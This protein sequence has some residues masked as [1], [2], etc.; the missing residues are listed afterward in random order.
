MADLT[1]E[2]LLRVADLF[3]R[4]K[5]PVAPAVQEVYPN[6][7]EANLYSR[8]CEMLARMKEDER[9]LVIQLGDDFLFCPLGNYVGMLERALAQIPTSLLAG[10]SQVIFAPL[11][12]PKDYGKVKSGH[13]VAY[14]APN[15]RAFIPNL[16]PINCTSASDPRELANKY[17][18]RSMSCIIFCDDFIGTGK[19]AGSALSEYKAMFAKNDDRVAVVSLVIQQCGYD[20]ISSIVPTYYAAKL[21]KGISDSMSLANRSEAALTMRRLEQSMNIPPEYAFG[22][23]RSEALVS[24]ARTPNNTFPVFWTTRVVDKLNWPAPFPR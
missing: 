19:T 15:S 3:A 13:T 6:Q 8:F 23:G 21:P 18:S 17:S 4:K 22:Y 16:T 24:M 11:V 10:V 12:A 7:R 14:F 9:E 5:W 20:K 2:F 1:P